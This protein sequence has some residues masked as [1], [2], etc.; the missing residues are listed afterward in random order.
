MK[1]KQNRASMGLLKSL[2]D[3]KLTS[4]DVAF[5]SQLIVTP[6]NIFWCSSI[7]WSSRHLL[8]LCYGTVEPFWWHN[9]THNGG[10]SL[11]FVTH[12]FINT[13]N[14]RF[15]T[16][17]FMT[18]LN[19][20]NRFACHWLAALLSHWWQQLCGSIGGLRGVNFGDK[21]WKRTGVLKGTWEAGVMRKVVANFIW[22]SGAVETC[23]S[24]GGQYP[25]PS[26]FHIP[27]PL[28]ATSVLPLSSPA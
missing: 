6:M 23:C 17:R 2:I 19:F 24:W 15:T 20:H 12:P 16:Q 5:G 14:H 4:Y 3:L 22:W 21:A 28:P 8:N 9:G 25:V 1:H 18:P 10:F 27:L 11:Y 7:Q 26:L 13:R